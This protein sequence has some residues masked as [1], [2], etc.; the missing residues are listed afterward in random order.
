[1]REPFQRRCAGLRTF[2]APR[3]EFLFLARLTLT[4]DESVAWS[5]GGIGAFE[6]TIMSTT[7]ITNET[8]QPKASLITALQLLLAGTKSNVSPDTPLTINGE[9]V[10]GADASAVFQK[11]LDVIQAVTTARA[12]WQAAVAAERAL[13]T[14][15]AAFVAAYKATILTLFG[16]RP[17]I[18]AQFGIKARKPTAKLTAAQLLQ[19]AAN[20]QATRAL[21]GTLG[22]KQK[23]KIKGKGAP[24]VVP[25]PVI[26]QRTVVP[27]EHPTPA[28]PSEPSKT[29]PNGASSAPTGTE[30]A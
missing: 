9:K 29:P 12:T 22:S 17:D 15:E 5:G 13:R 20:A 24:V 10:T 26:V 30:H 19:R 11:L 14:Q 4:A 27:A 23:A 18:L 25:P 16:N 2:F 1:M 3:Q 7:N 28:L 21:R 8:R 6:A